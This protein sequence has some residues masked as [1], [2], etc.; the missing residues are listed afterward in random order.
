MPVGDPTLAPSPPGAL[1]ADAAGYADYLDRSG[2]PV[3]RSVEAPMF[4]R[5][6]SITAVDGGE[7]DA[8]AIEVCVSSVGGAGSAADAE[9][10]LITVRTRQP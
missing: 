2:R 3:D 6:W 10:C 5:R 8:L 1:D 9:V 7:P 4:R